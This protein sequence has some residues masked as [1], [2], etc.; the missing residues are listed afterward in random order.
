MST[1]ITQQSTVSQKG[2]TTKKGEKKELTHIFQQKRVSSGG[3][4]LR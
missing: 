1:L 3:A 4:A 2:S